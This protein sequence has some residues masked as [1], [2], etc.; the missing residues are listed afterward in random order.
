M[1]QFFITV[2]KSNSG[3]EM[4]HLELCINVKKKVKIM[5]LKTGF[6]S[7]KELAQWMNMSYSGFRKNSDKKLNIL[8]SYCDYEKVHGGVNIK[9]IYINTYSGDLTTTD[10]SN[11]LEEIKSKTNGLS[12]ITGMTKK[13]LETKEEY[14]DMKFDTVRYRLTKAGN[15]AFGK[16]SVNSVLN[17]A[18]GVYGTRA[19]VWAIKEEG[20]NNYRYMTTEEAED[21]DKIIGELYADN[22]KKVKQA[23]L[24]E[25][26]F[27]ESDMEKEEY[28][29][30]KE[31]LKLDVFSLCLIAF[32]EKHKVSIV[33]CSEHDLRKKDRS[34]E[35]VWE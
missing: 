24:L 25:K 27:L 2:G 6:I 1:F 17:P 3:K 28:K 4:E 7:T 26:E 33:R 34:Q 8:K 12:S 19:M 31:E 22:A 16:N 15:I 9:E 30:L 23:A 5:Q 35:Y 20:Y 11:Y 29:K 10:I 13:F 21:F 18:P 14:K 32:K